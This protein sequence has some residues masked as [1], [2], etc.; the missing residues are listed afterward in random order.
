MPRVAHFD[1]SPLGLSWTI[2]E[3]MQRC[4]HALV[5]DGRVWLIDPVDADDAIERAESLGEIA[6][7]IQL[8]DRHNRDCAALA[9]RFD[10]PHHRIPDELPD[11]PFEVKTIVD[12]PK[13]NEKMLWWPDRKALVITEALVTVRELEVGGTGIGTHF[14]LRLLPP[15]AAAEHADAEHLLVGHGRS[16]HAADTGQR[17]QAAIGGSRRDFPRFMTR[18]PRILWGMR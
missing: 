16:L 2:A 9:E 4:S 15:K 12:G 5:D 6:G 18:L 10:V 7:V 8:L 11:T 1:E 13:W 14:L 3:S 17:V